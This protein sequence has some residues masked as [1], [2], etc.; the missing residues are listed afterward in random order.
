[1]KIKFVTSGVTASGIA[2]R[3]ETWRDV[4]DDFEEKFRYAI[5][6]ADRKQ[7]ENIV[8]SADFMQAFREAMR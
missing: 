7:P 3:S 5:A 2:W 8:V 6:A 4:P 1:M